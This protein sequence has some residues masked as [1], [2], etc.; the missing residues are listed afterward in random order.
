MLSVEDMI[1]ALA[2]ATLVV[3]AGFALMA[4]ELRDAPEGFQDAGGFHLTWRNRSDDVSDVTCVWAGH[5][6]HSAITHRSGFNA[7]A[8]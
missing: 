5:T 7:A 1:I 4:K 8:A 6:D 3:M 2:L